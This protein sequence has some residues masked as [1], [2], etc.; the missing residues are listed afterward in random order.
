MRIR[1]NMR[2][3]L[4]LT[5]EKEIPEFSDFE[6]LSFDRR[7]SKKIEIIRSAVKLMRNLEY[8]TR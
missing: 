3:S 6:K 2:D 7:K 4:A 5:Q 1:M 8:V